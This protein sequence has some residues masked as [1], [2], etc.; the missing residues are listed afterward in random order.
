VFLN[1]RFAIHIRRAAAWLLSLLVLQLTTLA[2]GAIYQSIASANDRRT[3][4]MPGK[5]V[6]I[7][8]YRLHIYC[9]GKHV[10]GQPTVVFEGG[11]GAPWLVW[12]LVQP[13]VA[14]HTRACSY[15]RAGYGWSDPGPQPRSARQMAGELHGLLEKAGETGPYL[16]VGHSLGG[17]IIRIYAAEYPE[18]VSGLLLVDARHEDFFTRMPTDYRRI[19]ETNL[20]NAQVLQII[21][22]FGITRLIGQNGALD[23]YERY[24]APLPDASEA[25]AWALMIYNPQH[26]AT[27]VSER[28]ASPESY[29][30]ARDSNLAHGL[31]LTV[32]SA[33][34]GVAAWKS[35]D[36]EISAESRA[37]W[38]VLQR[39]QAGLS[40]NSRW[41]IVPASGHYIHLDQPSAVIEA[42]LSMLG[43]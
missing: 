37:I 5:L 20:R 17:I 26:W 4:T 15:D 36:F 35:P 1:P 25:A 41:I 3:F 14:E 13:G 40:T 9:T 6:D 21:T 32:L 31:P 8:G 28:Q 16:L 24:L 11:L 39:E 27:A 33:E 19:D 22:P 10:D 30:Q 12:D 42:V 43:K 23:G 2:A 18:Q 29:Q 34:N 38:M 7:G